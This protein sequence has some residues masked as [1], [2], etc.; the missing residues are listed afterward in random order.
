MARA[1]N[2]G[3]LDLAELEA[4]SAEL[5]PDRVEMRIRARR[6]AVAVAANE[7]EQ[8]GDTSARAR[9]RGSAGA[10]G[11]FASQGASASAEN[12]ANNGGTGCQIGCE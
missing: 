11:H 10:E 4:Q 1:P 2:R 9:G 3:G 6:S 7:A 5:L 12:Q 8:S